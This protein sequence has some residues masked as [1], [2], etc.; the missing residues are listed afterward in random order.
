MNA[1]LE[2]RRA[3]ISANRDELR[4]HRGSASRT[5]EVAAASA[6]RTRTI[7]IDPAAS[8][9]AQQDGAEDQVEERARVVA[10]ETLPRERDRRLHEVGP[11]PCGKASVTLLEPRQQPR[12]RD[13]ALPDV[14]HLRARVA[15][16]DDQLLHLAEPG[17]RDAEEAVEHRR[18]AARSWTSAKPPPLRPGQRPF[19]DERG[20]RRREERV[21]RVAALAQNTRPR[22]GRERMPAAIAPR[23]R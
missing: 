14:E 12:H 21:D 15:E 16:V 20:E 10:L 2:K 8:L 9:V 5:R 23:I 18:L 13:G 19:G 17:G 3:Q 4:K 11:V 22:L 1:R 7:A 6:V